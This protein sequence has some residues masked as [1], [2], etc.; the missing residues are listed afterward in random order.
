VLD[1]HFQVFVKLDPKGRLVL[2]I[3]LRKKLAAFDIKTLHFA[4]HP[5]M[6]IIAFTPEKWKEQ[7]ESKLDGADIFDPRAMAF[8]HTVMAASCTVDVDR[9]GRL[10]IPP[11]LRARAGLE[12]ELVMHTV[13]GRL[14]IWAADRWEKRIE[15]AEAALEAVERASAAD[16]EQQEKA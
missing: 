10:L 12:R 13:P 2:P 1:E 16:G 15:D 4:Y 8:S 5:R 7:V 14:E 6:S 11:T 9:Q 3:R